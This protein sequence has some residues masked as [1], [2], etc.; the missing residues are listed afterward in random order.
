MEKGMSRLSKDVQLRRCLWI[1][2]T[3]L[4]HRKGISYDDMMEEWRH[5]SFNDFDDERIP[6]RSFGKYLIDIESFFQVSIR[7]DTHCGRYFLTDPEEIYNDEFKNRLISGFAVN[8]IL[9]GSEKLRHRIM[10][11]NIPSGE[12]FLLTVLEAM[13]KKRCIKV[14]Y[15]KFTDSEAQTKTLEPYFLKLFRQRWYVVAKIPNADGLRVYALDRV[16][17]MEIADVSFAVASDIDVKAFFIDCFGIE[18]NPEDYDVEDIKLK[19]YNTHSKCQYL[20][21]LPLHHS[22]KELERRDDYSIFQVTVYPTYDFMQEILS[23]GDEIEVLEP[24]WV[25][26]EFQKKIAAMAQRYR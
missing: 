26:N 14:I 24:T 18:H 17:D 2:K 7:Y 20:R 8:N 1:A 25:R 21:A 3:L 19:V 10:T 15:Q 13:Q 22:Q 16:K 23:H 9:N 11:E 6:K 5:S 12:K 4:T